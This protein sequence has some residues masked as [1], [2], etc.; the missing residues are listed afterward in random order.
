MCFAFPMFY[1]TC[2]FLSTFIPIIWAKCLISFTIGI[3]ICVMAWLKLRAIMSLASILM[4]MFSNTLGDC[5]LYHFFC[6]GNDR[7]VCA[8]R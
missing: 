5:F 1:A 8:I 4:N 7:W 2:L 3:P 6:C